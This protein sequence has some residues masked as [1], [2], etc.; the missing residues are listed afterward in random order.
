[1]EKAAQIENGTIII[2]EREIEP[3][4]GRKGAVVKVLG[5]GLCGSDIVKLNS[6]FQKDGTVLGHEIVAK[7]VDIDSETNFKQGDV[8]ITSHHIPCGKCDYCKSHNDVSM[9]ASFKRYPPLIRP[10]RI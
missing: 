2:K 8:I 9:C 5:C 1:M 3:L 7:I 6:I 10:R 4:Q